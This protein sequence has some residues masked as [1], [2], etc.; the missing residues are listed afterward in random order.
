VPNIQPST[1]L[2]ANYSEISAFCNEIQ[3]PVIIT[4][5]DGQNDLAVMS[6]EMFEILSGKQELYRL[7]DEGNEAINA[8][9]KNPWEDV[10]R[11]I[12]QGIVDGA[13]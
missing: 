1:I 6:M 2:G 11:N 9:Q 4:K 5:K 13:V 12:R 7:L 3:E 10:M 8:G